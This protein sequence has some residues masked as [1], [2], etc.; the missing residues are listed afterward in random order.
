LRVSAHAYNSLE[1]IDLVLEALARH[2]QLLA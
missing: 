1:D 2:R